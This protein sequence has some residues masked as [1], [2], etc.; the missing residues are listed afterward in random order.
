MQT[1]ELIA[2]ILG[3][4]GLGG[5]LYHLITLK[6]RKR[7]MATET[8]KAEFMTADEITTRYLAKMNELV[9]TIENLQQEIIIVKNQ[10]QRALEDVMR[11]ESIISQLME[12]IKQLRNQ[13]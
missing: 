9:A 11:K 2:A 10:L 13:R 3:G 7:K 6:L 1:H 8:L 4:T 12:E 5:G